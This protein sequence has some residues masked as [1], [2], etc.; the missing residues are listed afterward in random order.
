MWD[1]VRKMA[2]GSFAIKITSILG[3]SLL[4]LLLDS[5]YLIFMNSKGLDLN[6]QTFTIGNMSIAF[7][8]QWLPVFGVFLLSLVT[9][10]EAYYRIF[11]RRG[12][13]IDP[14]GR[15]RLARV[16]VLSVTCF[17]LVLFVPALIGSA[18]F[19]SG[20]STAG[21]SFSQLV[22]L[23]NSLLNNFGSLLVLDALWQYSI[24]QL[25]ASLVM[26]LVVWTFARTV[27][28]ARR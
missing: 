18:W 13:E 11:P 22:G 6:A 20:L 16:V 8:L 23:G 17:L 21:R 19:W 26:V 15:V 5:F 27:R 24:S 12:I 9:W 1:V 2:S 7:P 10:Y 28:R 25:V 3:V 14:L 4:I